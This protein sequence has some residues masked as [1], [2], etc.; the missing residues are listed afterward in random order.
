MTPPGRGLRRVRGSRSG[1]RAAPVP[2]TVGVS[3]SDRPRSA[4]AGPAGPA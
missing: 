1:F 4:G 3:G 2:R